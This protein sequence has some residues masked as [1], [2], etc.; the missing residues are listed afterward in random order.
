MSGGNRGAPGPGVQH[1]RGNC[2]RCARHNVPGGVDHETGHV[3]LRSHKLPDGGGWCSNKERVDAGPASPILDA[4]FRAAMADSSR[5]SRDT[6][7]E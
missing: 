1:A 5:V 4:A 2:P 7:E 3:I 6:R